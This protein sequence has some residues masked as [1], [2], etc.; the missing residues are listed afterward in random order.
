MRFNTAAKP[1][2]PLALDEAGTPTPAAAASICHTY[3]C[4]DCLAPVVLRAASR[5]A[6]AHF[7]HHANACSRGESALHRQSCDTLAA[8]VRAAQVHSASLPCRGCGTTMLEKL[9]AFE[10]VCRELPLEGG[11]RPDLVL[12]RYGEPVMAIEVVHTH[13]L[14]TRAMDRF[15]ELPWLE[16]EA[17]IEWPACL[18]P[19]RCRWRVQCISCEG[20]RTS[21]PRS[22]SWQLR[23]CWNCGCELEN[24]A[25][26]CGACGSDHA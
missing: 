15:G 10:H 5:R 2:I 17:A 19:R 12:L 13:A 23:E 16:V 1:A 3:R 25:A 9:P 21:G 11:I 26:A 22:E 8:A 14:D 24:L 6:R 7:A 18:M 4:P 20:S